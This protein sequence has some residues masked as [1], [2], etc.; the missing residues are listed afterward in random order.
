MMAPYRS[1]SVCHERQFKIDTFWQM[2]PLQYREGVRHVQ[3]VATKSEYQ[4]SCGV[5]YG[6][7]TSLEIDRKPDKHKVA[8]IEPRVDKRDHERTKAV[9]GYVAT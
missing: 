4:T 8:V 9:V 2:Q 6:L 3:V 5:E 7:Q 1:H